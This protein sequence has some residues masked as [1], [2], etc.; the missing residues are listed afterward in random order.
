[1]SRTKMVRVSEE[2]WKLLQR[3]KEELQRRGYASLEGLEDVLGQ[4]YE[5]EEG[6]EA[7]LGSL[8]A[9]LALG[10]IAAVGA[11]AI[12]KYL[13]DAAKNQGGRS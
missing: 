9:G 12:I 7:D 5:D 1:M 2:E 4:E 3:A 6:E 13:S 8:L 10:A 11:V